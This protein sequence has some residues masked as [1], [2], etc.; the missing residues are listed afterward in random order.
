MGRRGRTAAFPPRPGPAPSSASWHVGRRFHGASAPAPVPWRC[1]G[2]PGRRRLSHCVAQCRYRRPA[3]PASR[4]PRPGRSVHA[5]SL[6]REEARR[7][8]PLARGGRIHHASRPRTRGRSSAPGA[9][10]PQCSC[11]CSPSPR[12][13]AAA[14]T[15]P[16]R[17]A[18]SPRGP[19]VPPDD[20][21]WTP[22]PV[23]RFLSYP[24]RGRGS[25]GACGAA[26]R[27]AAPPAWSTGSC[28]PRRAA[29]RPSRTAGAAPSRASRERGGPP[30]RCRRRDPRPCSAGSW[31]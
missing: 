16:A 5:S 7:S 11:S 10:G 27:A 21:W 13:A 3:H 23:S 4:A 24:S 1:R 17:R 15:S 2:A 30:W 14:R 12:A 31:A 19:S 9:A 20:R 22:L 8:G 25:S 26:Q 6:G 18:R 29:R 28:R